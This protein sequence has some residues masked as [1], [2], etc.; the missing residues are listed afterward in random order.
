MAI[1]MQIKISFSATKVCTNIITGT[2]NH[3]KIFRYDGHYIVFCL[4]A[5]LKYQGKLNKNK[6]N[7]IHFCKNFL[8]LIIT[9]YL[10][11]LL[12]FW[13]QRNEREIRLE[14]RRMCMWSAERKRKTT[15]KFQ[16]SINLNPATTTPCLACLNL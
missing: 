15:T 8:M 11:E 3:G 4:Y 6:L 14:K 1:T 12:V 2:Q 9:M 13:Q 5:N 7:L 16:S 10:S